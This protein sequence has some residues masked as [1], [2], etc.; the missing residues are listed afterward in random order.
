[1]DERFEATNIEEVDAALKHFNHFHDDYVAGI[2]I[3]FENYKAINDE[4]RST[5]IGD[6]DKTII[7]TVNTHPYGKE[8][9]Q[10]IHVEFKDVKTFKI[11]SAEDSGPIWGILGVHCVDKGDNFVWDFEFV[12]TGSRYIVTCSEIVFSS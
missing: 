6:A 8:H 7:L 11:L 9:N 2:E 4:G 12:C 10:L 1:M 3:K 5:G